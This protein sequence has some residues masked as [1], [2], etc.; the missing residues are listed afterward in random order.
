MHACVCV[1]LCAPCSVSPRS[2]GAAV[3]PPAA[4]GPGGTVA[5]VHSVSEPMADGE[6]AC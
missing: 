2:V 3:G 6:A 4:A 5:K 1:R